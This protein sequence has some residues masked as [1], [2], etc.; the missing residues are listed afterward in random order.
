MNTPTQEYIVL[1]RGVEWQDN[2]SL[3]EI[4][5]ILGKFQA[6]NEK[7]SATGKIKGGQPLVHEGK[8]LSRKNGR[9]V[10]GPFM[11][12]KETIGGYLPGF[13]VFD[14][15]ERTGT[16]YHGSKCFITRDGVPGGGA[17]FSA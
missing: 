5:K 2:A 8:I 10:D 13:R 7:L 4:Q 15:E 17:S 6:W 11:E 12:S 9:I 16:N 14:F 3:E 1:I